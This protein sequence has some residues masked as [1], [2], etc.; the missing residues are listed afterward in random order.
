M[1]RV[2]TPT[3][4]T[5]PGPLQTKESSGANAKVVIGERCDCM[6]VVGNKKYVAST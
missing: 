1:W 2:T 5:E 6:H 3:E 4:R